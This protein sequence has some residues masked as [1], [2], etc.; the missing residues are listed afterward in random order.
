MRYTTQEAQA[1]LERFTKASA[2]VAD[3]VWIDHT[4]AKLMAE[5]NIEPRKGLKGTNRRSFPHTIVKYSEEMLRG[6]WLPINNGIGFNIN[7]EMTDG[8]HRVKA[9]LRSCSFNPSHEEYM[10]VVGGLEPGAKRKADTGRNR[11]KQQILLMEGE[12]NTSHLSSALRLLYCYDNVPYN[13]RGWE[14]RE[15]I[16][17][18][19]LLEQVDRCPEM[20]DAVLEGT[21]LR[22]IMSIP[23]AAVATFLGWRD[24]PE[25]LVG[26]FNARLADG[27]GLHDASTPV[28]RLREFFRNSDRGYNHIAQLAFWIKSFNGQM[29]PAIA[30]KLMHFKPNDVN[31]FPRIIVP[32]GYVWP[33][34]P[35]A[36]VEPDAQDS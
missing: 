28:Y 32:D 13:F 29:N 31:D 14:M 5:C 11:T 1:V 3:F 33:P 36:D 2:P 17:A 27:L 15:I 4:L 10:L 6:E 18:D 34:K 19:M 30:P 22:K 12:V 9:V 21:K 26:W 35:E 16:T 7:G 25:D 8:A 23:A 24:G 20:R